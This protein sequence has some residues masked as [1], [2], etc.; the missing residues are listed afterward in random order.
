M[1]LHEC[2]FE[3]KLRVGLARSSFFRLKQRLWN[4]QGI[5]KCT[6]VG[7]FTAMVTTTLLYGSDSW[8]RQELGANQLQTTQY[9][10]L[11]RLMLGSR[12]M[13]TMMQL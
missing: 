5:R 12:C 1:K 10:R 2:R 7:M 3:E 8:T 11:A 6:K 13:M 9:L 4:Q